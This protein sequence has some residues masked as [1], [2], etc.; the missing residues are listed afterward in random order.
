MVSLPALIN[1][2]DAVSGVGR[3]LTPRTPFSEWIQMLLDV[4]I[5]S[6]TVMA[7]NIPV[8]VLASLAIVTIFG[9]ELEQISLA[10]II[11]A[12]GLLVDNAVQVCDQSRTNQLQGMP[13]IQ[14]TVEGAKT[15]AMPMLSGTATTVV[16]FL[17]MAN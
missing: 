3:P 12:L 15:L 9:V 14:A 8:V 17:P 7:A 10:S 6:A 1:V 2:G 4:G 11:I 16:A 5:R 13:P